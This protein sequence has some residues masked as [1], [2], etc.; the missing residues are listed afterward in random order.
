M[1]CYITYDMKLAFITDL[2]SIRFVLMLYKTPKYIR[3]G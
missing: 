3:F 1:S 2:G